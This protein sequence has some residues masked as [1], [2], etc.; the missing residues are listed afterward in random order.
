MTLSKWLCSYLEPEKV[1]SAVSFE[2]TAVSAMRLIFSFFSSS[3]VLLTQLTE[4]HVLEKLLIMWTLDRLKKSWFLFPITSES[5]LFLETITL[6][7]GLFLIS[8][9]HKQRIFSLGIQTTFCKSDLLLSLKKTK[10]FLALE[11]FDFSGVPADINF[12]C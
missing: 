7:S 4:V 8:I 10:S 6:F 2:W 3:S 12:T 11:S 9:T 5:Q 1:S